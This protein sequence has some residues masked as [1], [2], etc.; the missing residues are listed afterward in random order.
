MPFKS[1]YPYI[2]FDL[3]SGFKYLGYFLKT[4]PQRVEDW[5]WLLKK[6]EKKN[7]NWCYRWLSLGGSFTLLKSVLEIQLVYCMSLAT[8]PF[9]VLNALRKMM[10][11]FLWRRNNES[12]QLHLCKWEHITISN[13]FGGWGIHNIYDFNKAL[14]ANSL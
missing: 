8:I 5:G 13:I 11:N 9:S 12:N 4:G 3:A 7:N 2:F 14:A 6:M 10:F 1:L